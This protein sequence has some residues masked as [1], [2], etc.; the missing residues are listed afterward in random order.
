[1]LW[2]LRLQPLW[3]RRPCSMCSSSSPSTLLLPPPSLLLLLLMATQRARARSEAC[4]EVPVRWAGRQQA[5]F[6]PAAHSACWSDSW[7]AHWSGASSNAACWVG[8]VAL[9]DSN[10]ADC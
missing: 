9:A 7:S 3:P 2:L 4:L 1:M 8:K 5:V 6:Q 10:E